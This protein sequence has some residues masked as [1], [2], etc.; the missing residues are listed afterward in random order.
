MEIKLKQYGLKNSCGGPKMSGITSLRTRCVFVLANELVEMINASLSGIQVCKLISKIVKLLYSDIIPSG[1]VVN[2]LLEFGCVDGNSALV[3]FAIDVMHMDANYIC[4]NGRTIFMNAVICGN[5]QTVEFL[6][7]HGV[8]KEARDVCGK[9][10]LDYAIFNKDFCLVKLLIENGV[11][12]NR[13]NID[14]C[15][16]YNYA[17]CHNYYDEDKVLECCVSIVNLRTRRAY[18]AA[19]TWLLTARRGYKA[20]V[21][22]DI[23]EII[24]RDVYASRFSPIWGGI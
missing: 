18:D 4:S 10:A 15:R 11:K 7:R 16:A 19:M 20:Y 6:L 22:R 12:V 21:A 14:A 1:D 24:A 2:Q 13:S 3:K 23:A 8:D 5:I 17:S 9:S